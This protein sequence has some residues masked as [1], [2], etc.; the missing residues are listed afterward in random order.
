MKL[1]ANLATILFYAA[2]NHKSIQDL[3]E[4]MKQILI[5]LFM[6]GLFSA[7]FA[8]DGHNSLNAATIIG[9]TTSSTVGIYDNIMNASKAHRLANGE[10]IEDHYSYLKNNKDAVFKKPEQLSGYVSEEKLAKNGG[11]YVRKEIMTY[12]QYVNLGLENGVR[13]DIDPERMV[14]VFTSRFS[15]QHEVNEQLIEGGSVT[16]SYD[17]ESGD[18]LSVGVDA[19]SG[20]RTLSNLC[21]CQAPHTL[22]G[23]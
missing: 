14:W 12:R 7:A 5:S 13:H 2:S 9:A 8:N 11:K 16:A 10:S 22:K 15:G 6:F 4:H 20:A 18:F 21:D 19:N 17:A 3:G 23:A 1:M